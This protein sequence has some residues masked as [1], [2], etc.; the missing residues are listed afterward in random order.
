LAIFEVKFFRIDRAPPKDEVKTSPQVPVETPTPPAL[1]KK[2]I[3]K[4]TL[5]GVSVRVRVLFQKSI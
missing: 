4:E 3:G 2:R 5:A 1:R